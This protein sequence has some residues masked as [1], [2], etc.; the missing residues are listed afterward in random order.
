MKNPPKM[1]LYCFGLVWFGLI[2]S[3]E[4]QK[5]KER[6]GSETK[7]NG[8]KVKTHIPANMGGTITMACATDRL[9]EPTA[10]PIVAA[11]S[12]S[13]MT[14]SINQPNPSSSVFNGTNAYNTRVNSIAG[15]ILN[16]S[17]DKTFVQ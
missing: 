11:A 5:E 14:K 12:A 8:N 16:G 7:I 6:K 1:I 9:Q 2:L 13:S 4:E 17:S 10:R 15:K 3:N